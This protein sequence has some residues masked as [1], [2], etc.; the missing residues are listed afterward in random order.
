[1]KQLTLNRDK[2]GQIKWT[3]EIIAQRKKNASIH[4]EMLEEENDAI[5][6]FQLR[7]KDLTE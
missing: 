6:T 5:L 7:L 4:A 2:V 1:M 3:K